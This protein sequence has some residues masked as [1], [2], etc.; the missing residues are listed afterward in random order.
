ML[1]RVFEIDMTACSQ[2]GGPLSIIAA[3][4][5]PAVIAKTLADLGL[6]PEPHPVRRVIDI[7]R[8]L[9]Y[10]P[11]RIKTVFKA[12]ISRRLRRLCRLPRGDRVRRFVPRA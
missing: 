11:R 2:C 8:R 12:R 10:N 5:D 1:K 3:I 9:Q 7:P 4:E 6:P